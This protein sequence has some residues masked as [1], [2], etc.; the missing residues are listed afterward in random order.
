MRIFGWPR[1]QRVDDLDTPDES[2]LMRSIWLAT[3]WLGIYTHRIHRLQ[4][5][6]CEH[7]HPW[8]FLIVVLRGG[9][10]EEIEGKRYVRR[11][12]YIGW[13]PRSFRHRVIELRKKTTVT[14]VIRGRNR[15]RWNFY[16]NHGNRPMDW[17]DYVLLHPE[18]RAAWCAGEIDE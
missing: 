11:P 10:V 6:A 17:Q 1:K 13:R 16:N 12:G 8:G 4:C 14:L 7:S 18:T 5:S 9:Y 15:K 2:Y 3:K